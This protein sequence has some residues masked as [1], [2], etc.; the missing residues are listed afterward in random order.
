MSQSVDQ[1]KPSGPPG[2][3]GVVPAAPE[4]LVP[5]KSRCRRILRSVAVALAASD[6]IA[7]TV[8]LAGGGVLLFD[9]PSS[10][11]DQVVGLFVIAIVWLTVFYTF[12][13]YAIAA[14]PA[15]DEFRR[16]IAATTIGVLVIV[17]V[18]VWGRTSVP[19]SAL[20]MSWAFVLVLEL[21]VRR[22]WRWVTWQLRKSGRL[23]RK[24]LVVGAD[25]EARRLSASLER[26]PTGYEPI[27]L[28]LARSGRGMDLAGDAVGSID[29]LERL[30]REHAVECVFVASS[31]VSGDMLLQVTRACR[32]A[33]IEMRVSANLPQILTSRVC[34]D[35][36]G[37]LMAISI[38]P[39]RLTRVQAALKGFFDV[40]VASTALV[41]LFPVIAAVWIAVRATSGPPALFHQ[42]RVTK[43]LRTFRVH[44]FRTM[45]PDADASANGLHLKIDAPFFKLQEDPR[46]TRFGRFLRQFS[47]DELP[48]LWNVIRGE[49][50][51]VGPRPLR[52]EQV[53]A[54]QHLLGSRHEVKAG[55]TGWWQI[56]GRNDVSSVDAVKMDTFYIENWS[57]ALDVYILLKTVGTLLARKGAY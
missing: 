41:V 29:D 15:W 2:D 6:V 37:D 45:I 46:V 8:G 40:V 50:S 27:G 35:G 12:G 3:G 49:M 11:L 16:V 39:V 13:L 18:G 9:R 22:A 26:G 24:T 25:G 47:L 14:L 43:G 44:K 53:R 54:E 48:Q 55:L 7:A 51:L 32:R 30:I 28:V 31:E 33:S 36:A 38:R 19:R 23:V 10:W 42:E 34:I 21:C 4:G 56:H 5:A 52:I 57:L 20:V 17:T 1:T